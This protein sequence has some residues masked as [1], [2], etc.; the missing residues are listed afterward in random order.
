MLLSE[1]ETSFARATWKWLVSRPEVLVGG[2]RQWNNLELDQLLSLPEPPPPEATP[3]DA[4]T[5]EVQTS[6][7]NPKTSHKQDM[8]SRKPEALSTRPR[9]SVT[10]ETVWRRLTGHGVDYKRIPNL[11]WRCLLGIASTK[12]EGILQGDLRRLVQQDKRSVPKR[13]DFLTD[14]G[15]IAKRSLFARGTKTSKLWLADLAPPLFLNTD[16]TALGVNVDMSRAS[17]TKDASPIPW[18]GKWTGKDIDI[19]SFTESLLAI[20]KAWGVMKY[21]DLRLKM[22]LED[23]RWQMRAMSRLCRKLVDMGIL[24][25]AAATFLNSRKIWKDCIKFVRDPDEDEWAT[26]LATGQKTS[27]KP[28]AVG[29]RRGTTA[30]SEEPRD[31]EDAEA[32]PAAKVTPLGWTP[33]KPIAHTILDAIREAGP[34]GTSTPQVSVSTVGYGFKRYIGTALSSMA[35]VKQPSHLGRY[36]I[37]SELV[38]HKKTS[39]YMYSTKHAPNNAPNVQH[40]ASET[41]ASAAAYGGEDAFGS[42]NPQPVTNPYGFRAVQA[43][44]FAEG[45]DSAFRATLSWHPEKTRGGNSHSKQTDSSPAEPESIVEETASS[46]TPEMLA[47]DDEEQRPSKRRRIEAEAEGVE[48]L[49][50]DEV[51]PPT[52][53]PKPS[54]DSLAVFTAP[55]EEQQEEQLEEQPEEQLKEQPPPII[56]ELPGKPPGAYIGGPRPLKTGRKKLGRPKKSLNVIFKFDRFNLPDFLKSL[57]ASVAILAPPNGNAAQIEAVAESKSEAERARLEAQSNGASGELQSTQEEEPPAGK[58]GG[59]GRSAKKR[60]AASEA[61]IYKCDTC[62]G[63]WKNDLGLKYHLTKAQTP[64]NPNYVPPPPVDR[65]RK[66][67][68]MLPPNPFPEGGPSEGQ[69][70]AAELSAVDPPY[71]THTTMRRRRRLLR[72]VQ[73]VRSAAPAF[74]GLRLD[75]DVVE[76][77]LSKQH[78]Q[79][80]PPTSQ[81]SANQAVEASSTRPDWSFESMVIKTRDMVEVPDE[82]SPDPVGSQTRPDQPNEPA[83]PSTP[84]RGRESAEGAVG[85][86]EE[87]QSTTTATPRPGRTKPSGGRTA[88]ANA[89]DAHCYPSEESMDTPLSLDHRRNVK[90]FVPSGNYRRI[91]TESRLRSVQASEIIEYLL[92]SN[93]G[94]FPGDKAL[95]YAVIRVFL[96]T[97]SGQSPPTFKNLKVALRTLD[98]NK[99]ARE[100]VHAF[101]DTRGKLAAVYM[102]VRTDLDPSGLVPTMLKHKMQEAYPALFIPAAFSP[103]KK[104]LRVLQGFE[105]GT[106]EV[107]GYSKNGPKFRGRREAGEVEVLNAPYYSQFPHS[108]TARRRFNAGSSGGAAKRSESESPS[109]RAASRDP[110]DSLARRVT[111]RPRLTPSDL[112]G[113]RMDVDQRKLEP[114]DARLE[115]LRRQAAEEYAERYGHKRAEEPS[116]ATDPSGIP[117]DPSLEAESTNDT[118]AGGPLSVV[119]AINTYGLFSS[120]WGAKQLGRTSNAGWRA[121]LARINNPGLDSLP[122]SFFKNAGSNNLGQT[123][124]PGIHFLEPNSHLETVEASASEDD[125]VSLPP[126]SSD[127]VEGAPTVSPTE[128]SGP[129]NAGQIVFVPSLTLKGDP[130]TGAWP[131]LEEHYFMSEACDKSL[132]LD[133]QRLN[134]RLTSAQ[135]TPTSAEDIIA[136]SRNRRGRPVIWADPL[137]GDFCETVDRIKSWELSDE[138]AAVLS[139][140]TIAPD[141]YNRNYINLSP[142]VTRCKMKPM[143]LNWSAKNSFDLDTLPYCDLDEDMSIINKLPSPLRRPMGRP[144]KNPELAEVLRNAGAQQGG[145]GRPGNSTLQVVALN[146]HREHTAYPSSAEEYIVK[147][148][149][150]DPK[151]RD[152]WYND[153]TRIAAFVCVTTLAGGV[154]RSVDWGLMLRL[155]PETPLSTQRRFWIATRKE[156]ASTVIRLTERFRK[157]FLKAYENNEV[158]PL[159]YDNLLAY[160]WKFLV[161]WTRKLLVA[162]TGPPDL[163]ASLEA[164]EKQDLV[165]ADP[166]YKPRDWRESYFNPIRSYFDR[167]QDASSQAIAMPLTRDPEPPNTENLVVAMSW[168]RALCVTPLTKYPPQTVKEKLKQLCGLSSS[169]GS[170]LIEEASLVLQDQTMISKCTRK[171]SN[172]RPWRIHDRVVKVLDKA[173]QQD[174]YARAAAFKR[175]LDESFRRGR[176]EQVRYVCNDGAVMA[177]LNL[178]AH[179][180]IAVETTGQPY[181]PLGYEPFNYETRKYPKKYH[182]FKMHIRPTAAYIYDADDDNNDDDGGGGGG[183]K[184][185][186]L[187]TFRNRV[188]AARPPLRGP[189]GEIPLWCDLFGDVDNVRWCKYLGAVL[190]ML[191]ARGAMGPDELAQALKPTLMPFE[192]RLVL[193]W[194]R[195]LGLLAPKTP[196]AALAPGEWWWLVVDAQGSRGKESGWNSMN[197]ITE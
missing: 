115:R 119:D 66:R 74:R 108:A 88:T 125:D 30:K 157:E 57:P 37:N 8:K 136:R 51:L 174:K 13:T 5:S 146:T 112:G 197:N 70:G 172:G 113:E 80:V 21:S 35:S 4:G 147:G 81:D 156:K 84:P 138:G 195:E 129:R 158:P 26:I 145:R 49:V 116:A 134:Y 160:D 118:G 11:E 179:R 161:L 154:G 55:Q 96:K 149:G 69:D 24:R 164:L 93:G 176:E 133:G 185:N 141:H 140:G 124:Y 100:I 48:R 121:R 82:A 31:V 58:K 14:K 54:N 78:R 7:A 9:I 107:E 77:D 32:S 63:T 109:K 89:D 193:D 68:R 67:R 143:T 131:R 105:K 150:E 60:G 33:E 94:A 183:D 50:A 83:A 90:P 1:A 101:R 142:P 111:K 127:A 106:P 170:K 87:I 177:M 162:D 41:P 25:Y 59:K 65:P 64:C 47:D 117:I 71:Q 36:D 2:G 22:G 73:L 102:M 132:S 135:N 40:I 56:E 45:G 159:D 44:S 42:S 110:H 184:N 194:G 104:E 39:T 10:E 18:H 187:T 175:E 29:G 97:F 12:R 92:D 144:R 178:Q 76:N 153:H 196:G 98:H 23:L 130:K 43:S 61:K 181:V 152:G 128:F 120:R 17:L 192:A 86:E 137:L 169:D 16:G 3:A 99:Q 186:P 38:R 191:S 34:A 85:Q 182:H 171:S 15:Y 6:R 28:V 91:P 46:L 27:K 72:A 103:S 155:F 62:G 163:P 52:D 165:A 53:D 20:V 151:A 173:G 180:R 122:A 75:G 189:R 188:R 123:H 167:F 166:G 114:G 168:I 79:E 190:F 139:F 95:F 19:E 148:Q 126:G